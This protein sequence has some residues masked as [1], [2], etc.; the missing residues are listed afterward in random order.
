MANNN[1]LSKNRT[2]LEG[3]FVLSLYNNPLELYGD[4]PINP[5]KDLTT[6][7]GRFYYNLGYNMVKKGVK[8][9][10]E[11]SIASFLNDFPELK[12]E[13]E[14]RGGWK[15]ISEATSILDPDNIE[16][17]YEALIKNNLLIR[18]E[19]QGFGIEE[20]INKLNQLTTADE[21]VDYFEIILNTIALNI[22]HDLKL[23]TLK[24][25]E[26]DIKRKK[27]GE[28]RGLQFKDASPL[29]NSF[30]GGI[31]RKGLTMFASYTNGGKTSFV[32][33]N[34]VLPIVNQGI[35]ACIISNEQDS[36]V[37][38]DLLYL[39]VLTTD[40]DYWGIDRTKLKSLDFTKEDWESYKKADKIV[41]EKYLSNIVFQRVYDY[42]MKNVKRTVKK[43]SRQGVSLFVYDTFKVDST[44]E[45]I[46]QSFLNDS[47]ELFQIASKENVAIIT[48]VQIALSTKGK[49]RW[50]N[51]GVLANSKQIS[52]IY[53]EIFTF[54]DVWQD[55]YAGAPQDIH[56]YY[57]VQDKD[58]GG[59]FTREK[60][61]I[62]IT[63]ADGKKYKIFFHTKSRNGEVGRTV[64]Y[65]FKP[66][67]NKWKELGLCCVGEDNRL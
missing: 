21:V 8:R 6:S 46:W 40:L 44:T 20:N 4:Y 30:C 2:L 42:S 64:L 35:K 24:I 23:Q 50:L 54:R 51:E 3:N 43:L 65:E 18:L 49:V 28:Q 66:Y 32:F 1:L 57:Y 48:P 39:H 41:E 15:A 33:E 29:L 56:P 62:N 67:A 60:K 37:F 27:S 55:E 13:Y 5:D 63:Y 47:K 14:N 45:T 52:E 22:T 61:E 7:D 53:E 31:P 16:A 9:F 12:K 26:E 59:T 19:K 58:N 34:V 11:I 36:I 38:K 17:Y 10:D 25:T